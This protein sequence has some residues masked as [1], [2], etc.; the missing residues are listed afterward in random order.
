MTDRRRND[1]RALAMY[2]RYQAGL[3]LAQVAAEFGCTRQSVYSMFDARGW[4]MRPKPERLPEV[5]YGGRKY[6]MRNTGY[7]GATTGDRHL[8]HR[9]MWQDAYGPIPDQFDIHH[10]DEVK[11]HNELSNFECLSKSD[12]TRLYSP[13]CNQF[14]HKCKHA[15][16]E[17]SDDVENRLAV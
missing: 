11:T 15:H 5:L 13:S 9:R 7:Y 12:H 6:T 14:S 4:E 16:R 3:S 2:E 8:L 10:L 1:A 17:E